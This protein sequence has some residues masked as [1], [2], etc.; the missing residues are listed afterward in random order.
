[1][2]TYLYTRTHVSLHSRVCVHVHTPTHPPWADQGKPEACRTPAGPQPEPLQCPPRPPTV[3][4]PRPWLHGSFPTPPGVKPCKFTGDFST[5]PSLAKEQPD[6][7]YRTAANPGRGS[8]SPPR[9]S[10]PVCPRKQG[11]VTNTEHHGTQRPGHGLPSAGLSRPSPHGHQPALQ[12]SPLPTR[13]PPTQGRGARE[14]S[15]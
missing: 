3:F 9:H 6:S 11:W 13:Q 2:H 12:K 7:L 5:A 1:M 10:L 8:T 4:P 15:G 14:A